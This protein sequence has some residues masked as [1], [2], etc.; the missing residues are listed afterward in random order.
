ML[1]EAQGH[2]LGQGCPP[3][4]L[5]PS[6]VLGKIGKT[7]HTQLSFFSIYSILSK[8]G[9]LNW[10]WR[11]PPQRT[12]HNIWKHFDS[13]DGG[14]C[15]WS[16]Y[17]WQAGT[18]AAWSWEH[19]IRSKGHIWRGFVQSFTASPFVKNSFLELVIC[20]MSKFLPQIYFPVYTQPGRSTSKPLVL[21]MSWTNNGYCHLWVLK[22]WRLRAGPL[23][24]A[25]LGPTHRATA[26]CQELPDKWLFCVH[27]CLICKRLTRVPSPSQDCCKDYTSYPNAQWM[28]T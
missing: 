13:H 1:Q 14:R 5:W 11:T 12:F 7:W 9:V 27:H 26:H 17:P 6:T 16:P 10:G 20:L 19:R 4:L 25:C 15:Y 23:D 2:V 18:E 3:S 28:S 22:K 21:C 24:A 8:A